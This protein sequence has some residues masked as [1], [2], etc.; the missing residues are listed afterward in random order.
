MLNP[1]ERGFHNLVQEENRFSG[2]DVRII[3]DETNNTPEVVDNN[4]MVARVEWR[5]N[6][7]GE[8]IQY[9]DLTFGDVEVEWN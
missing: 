9:V 6:K 3:C 8:T 1:I 4:I 2:I 5:L 7:L